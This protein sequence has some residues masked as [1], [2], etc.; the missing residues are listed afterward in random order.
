MEFLVKYVENIVL[1]EEFITNKNE[2]V[3]VSG[4]QS[5]F[6]SRMDP[7]RVTKLLVERR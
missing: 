3:P 4:L 5:T 2:P 7:R 6:S 1:I